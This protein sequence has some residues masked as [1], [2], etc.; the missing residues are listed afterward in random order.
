MNDISVA[1]NIEA[2]KKL[3]RLIRAHP[4]P[5]WRSFAWTIMGIMTFCLIGGFL[6]RLPE[7]TV[8]EGKV[9]PLGDLKVVQHLEG[10]IIQQIFV[11]EGDQVREGQ[12]LIQ[13]DVRA[14]GLSQDELEVQ[15]FQQLAIRA[16]LAAEAV[17]GTPS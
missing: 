10:G 5:T 3:E 11:A 1:M 16:R 9:V 7:V 13:L 8:A 14:A 12:P 2:D 6:T 15:L 17:G 4:I